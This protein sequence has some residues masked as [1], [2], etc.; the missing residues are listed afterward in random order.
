MTTEATR[1][2]SGYWYA[3]DA[4]ATGVDV[5]NALRH[6]RAAESA[7]QRRTR[8]AL[9]VGEN[10]L[11]ALRFLRERAAEQLPV[12][13]RD[14]ARHLGIT[15][16]ST[17]ALVERLVRSGH[18]DRRDDPSDR[19]G[20]LLTATGP[21]MRRASVVL[22]ELEDRAFDV[23]EELDPDAMRLI[24]TFLDEVAAVI[25]DEAEFDDLGGLGEQVS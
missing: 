4:P 3:P 15:P 19:R 5:L 6:Y 20:V 24:V 2:G 7:A 11:A 8:E 9:G 16:A 13:A 1:S 14:L 17:S 25:D 12:N 22:D 23:V 10:A 18:V 21:A